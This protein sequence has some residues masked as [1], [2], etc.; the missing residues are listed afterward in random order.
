MGIQNLFMFLGGI[1][2]FIFGI[3]ITSKSFETFAFG[4]FRKFLDKVTAK[5]ILGVL[6]GTVFT[7]IIQSSSATTVTVVSLANSGTLNFESTLGIIFG[8]NIGT[9][10]TAQIIAF[11]LNRFSLV[12]FAVGFLLSMIPKKEILR[13]LGRGIMGFGLIFIGMQFMEQ[14]VSP[15]RNSQFFVDLFVKMSK[16]PILGVLVSTLFTGIQQSSSVTVGIVQ[17]LG[18]EGLVDLNAAFSLII[19]ANIGTTVTA[20]L[21]SLG[22][23]TQARRAGVSHLIFNVVGGI[24]FLLI[25]RPYLAFVSRTSKDLVRQIANAH[26][27]F[28]VICTLLFLPFTYKFASLVKKLVPG[29]EIVV[30]GGPKHIDK[31]LLKMPSFAI[32]AIYKE[33][34]NM[35][36]MVKK[37]LLS[38][39][40]MVRE[41][42]NKLAQNISLRENAINAVNKEIQAFAPLVTS[43]QLTGEQA[44]EVNLLINVASQVERI[45]DIVKGLSE[46]QIEKMREGILFSELAMQDLSKMLDTLKTEYE[47]VENNFENFTYQHFKQVE[48]MEQSIDDLEIELRDAHVQRL[49]NGICSAEAGIIYVD[50][51]S[52]FERISDHI[53][54][55]ARLLKEKENLKENLDNN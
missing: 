51:L 54:K 1:S 38:V 5:P 42:S 43:T 9:T 16:K 7:S 17:A 18:S 39:C 8:A 26:T 20:L 22:T 55:I 15:L 52:D 33:V 45:G 11:K 50:M 23:N 13:E 6:L 40:L 37:N 46:L 49:V 24:I 53:Y 28:N 12:I 47:I 10:V 30:E 36:G 35:F 3:T 44:K 27:L 41:N 48:E 32:D 25:F 2:L 29:E 21:A 19:G 34:Y 31:R 14:A 4:S